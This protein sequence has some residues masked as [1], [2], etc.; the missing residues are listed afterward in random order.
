MDRIVVTG[1]GHPLAWRLGAYLL[2]RGHSVVAVTNPSEAELPPLPWEVRPKTDGW[3][4]SVFEGA[5]AVFHF[6]DPSAPSAL[7]EAE[8]LVAA[9]SQSR[10]RP[11]ALVAVSSLDV[12]GTAT[13]VAVNESAGVVGSSPVVA[14][15]RA[16]RALPHGRGRVVL[17]RLASVFR[18]LGGVVGSSWV[19]EDDAVRLL[20]HC[21]ETPSLEGA[22]HVVA[23]ELRSSDGVRAVPARALATGFRFVYRTYAEAQAKAAETRTD[24][25]DLDVAER[26]YWVPEKPD[27][28]RFF[29]GSVGRYRI[30]LKGIPLAW[31][32]RR[33]RVA[34]DVD[35]EELSRGAFQTFQRRQRVTALGQ[36]TLVEDAVAFRVRGGALLGR[37]IHQ[38]VK[39]R[40]F[41]ALDSAE[42]LGDPSS[43]ESQLQ[44]EIEAPLS[45]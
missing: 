24:W 6:A 23:P 22:V 17:A 30:S 10:G 33:E 44:T 5:R 8:G 4:A 3:D 25:S 45:V 9:L 36:G 28:C 7:A 41:A 37:W 26:V 2:D 29:P 43:F 34:N 1:A 42:S 20:L 38:A 39:E 18:W 16:L 31:E 35:G 27:L 13:E 21:M 32:T 14:Y 40:L 15:E 19:Q 12:F 11:L